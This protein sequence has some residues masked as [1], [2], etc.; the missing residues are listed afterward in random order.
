M[1]MTKISKQ[2]SIRHITGC[3]SLSLCGTFA[4][5]APLPTR[6]GH[7]LNCRHQIGYDNDSTRRTDLRESC[8]HAWRSSCLLEYRYQQTT[9]DHKW[10]KLRLCFLR[11]EQT[12]D[13]AQ[14]L[15]AIPW[16]GIFFV[17]E[18]DFFD[19]LFD[20]TF[21]EMTNLPAIWYTSTVWSTPLKFAQNL[22]SNPLLTVS[23][24][25][26]SWTL[27]MVRNSTC[28]FPKRSGQRLIGIIASTKISFLMQQH[29][30]CDTASAQIWL[31]PA[32][33]LRMSSISWAMQV[34]RSPWMYMHILTATKPLRIL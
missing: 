4:P 27:G 29:T 33:I 5:N 25:F 32:W 20:Y 34:S 21:S 10:E 7:F 22:M 23:P 8:T 14:A 18:A 1:S 17:N 6:N 30:I 9:G 19:F 24:V 12:F 13:Q 16:Q 31:T 26:C 11:R 15:W 3:S 28:T 2:S